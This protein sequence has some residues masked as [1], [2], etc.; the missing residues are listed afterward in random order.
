MTHKSQLPIILRDLEEPDVG[1]VIKSWLES[2]LK[3]KATTISIY[4]KEHRD[5]IKHVIAHD[6]VTTEVIC[7]K[8][9]E[10]HIIGFICYESPIILH[11]IYIKYPFRH[12]GIATNAIN[13]CLSGDIII[14]HKFKHKYYTYNPYLLMRRYE[15]N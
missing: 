7:L 5:L 11:Y 8:E 9:D 4:E 15:N 12:L 14:T 2:N 13:S 3:N 1:F 10:D 6:K